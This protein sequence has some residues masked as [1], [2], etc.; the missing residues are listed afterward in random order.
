MVYGSYIYYHSPALWKNNCCWSALWVI[1]L[2]S[3]FKLLN[4]FSRIVYQGFNVAISHWSMYLN[5]QY[6]LPQMTA[7]TAQFLTWKPPGTD[8]TC[9]RKA[10]ETWPGYTHD[11]PRRCQCWPWPF[12]GH[13]QAGHPQATAGQR[14]E[15]SPLELW[16]R[17]TSPREDGKKLSKPSNQL[18]RASGIAITVTSSINW[19]KLQRSWRTGKLKWRRM[20]W[21]KLERRPS[22][23]F[24]QMLHL[25][26]PSWTPPAQLQQEVLTAWP[27][28]NSTVLVEPLTGPPKMVHPFPGTKP[29]KNCWCH[30]HQSQPIYSKAKQGCQDENWPPSQWSQDVSCHD[31]PA[32]GDDTKTLIRRDPVPH[33]ICLNPLP[34]W[35]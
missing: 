25:P 6:T 26:L 30:P 32:P 11:S 33:S 18:M 14:I 28:R 19:M 31:N 16:C 10:E 2:D 20:L 24:W 21:L 9:P 23:P 22:V 3:I 34:G 35:K 4:N 1:S 5:L 17:S 13:R 12:Q 27:E 29:Q 8:V 15:W 7:Q